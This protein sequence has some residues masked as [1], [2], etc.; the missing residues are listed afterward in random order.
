MVLVAELGHKGTENIHLHGIL[1]TDEKV[2]TIREIWGYGFI[3]C[4][5]N[6]EPT[7]V[8]EQTVNYITKYIMKTDSKNREYKPIILNSAGIGADYLKRENS[9]KHTYKG[10]D[11]I[12]T[13]KNRSG[14]EV[15]LPTYWRNKIWTDEEREDLWIDMLNRDERYVCGEKVENASSI[16]GQQEY[17]SLVEHYRHKNYRLGFGDNTKDWDR[18]RY[19]NIS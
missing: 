11:T 15:A 17:Y 4:G 14:V 12:V 9:K 19:E 1:W 7:Y 5:Y 10:D 3:W 2:Q 8:S 18:K 6:D 13:Y 16:E